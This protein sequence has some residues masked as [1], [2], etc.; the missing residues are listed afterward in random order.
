MKKELPARPSLEHLKSQA[1][2]LLDAHQKGDAEALARVRDALPAA[3][4]KG[5]F[6]LK[7]HDAQSVV[8]REYG[9]PSWNELR[10]HVLRTPEIIAALAQPHLDVPIPPEV[11]AAIASAALRT[12]ERASLEAPLPVVAVRNALL[13]AGSVAPFN[14]GRPASIAAIEAAQR[15]AGTL[16]IFS[17]TDAANEAPADGDLH[18]VG[19]AAKVLAFVRTSAH[20]SWLVV[21]ALEWI[22]MESLEQ[23]APFLVA[24]VAP[25]AVV[26]EQGPEVER[27]HGLLRARVRELAAAMPN[28]EVLL[29]IIEPMSALELADAT[30]ANLPYGVAEKARY[31]A[32]PSLR[33]RL[34]YLLGLVGVDS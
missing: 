7:L 12:G 31:A 23:R 10:E 6:A 3:R 34:S 15:G 28:A 4:G 27:L 29:R 9:F 32:E 30:V 13:T 22:R 25:F 20:G 16:A 2:D 5:D 11:T 24:R 8:A 21:R 18:G 1:K 19:C 26:E 33:A 14:I 17:Q